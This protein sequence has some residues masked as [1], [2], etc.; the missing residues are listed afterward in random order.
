[1]V[2]GLAQDQRVVILAQAQPTPTVHFYIEK[3]CGGVGMDNWEA[4]VD[5]GLPPGV[6]GF[7]QLVTV[8][9]ALDGKVH[10]FG[11]VKDTGYVWW[12]YQNPDKTA[13]HGVRG[14]N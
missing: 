6:P 1:M 2:A 13:R 12:I 3:P 14:N 4:P 11:L 5:L 9:G 8:P 7:T 10:V